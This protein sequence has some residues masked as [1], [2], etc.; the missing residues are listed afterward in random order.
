MPIGRRRPCGQSSV[1]KMATPSPIGTAMTMAMMEVVIVP[2]IAA[3]APNFSVTGFQTAE[4]KNPK[5]NARKAGIDPATKE[6]MTPLRIRRTTMADALVTFSKT[7]SPSLSAFRA[8]ALSRDAVLMRS[9]F[10]N[11]TSANVRAPDA[12][13]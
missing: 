4:V 3:T 5:P 11:V 1:K 6:T 2:E 9:A 12:R 7:T 13:P 8:A 10:F